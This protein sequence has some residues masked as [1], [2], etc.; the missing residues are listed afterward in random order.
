MMDIKNIFD[1]LNNITNTLDNVNIKIDNMVFRIE[2]LENLIKDKS[3]LNISDKKVINKT[4][5]L[6][7]LEHGF[8]LEKRFI[9]K[10]LEKNSIIGDVELFKE[11]YLRDDVN[12]PFNRKTKN[13]SYYNN[14]WIENNNNYIENTLIGNIIN[15][16]IEC[17]RME[18]DEFLNS[19][20]KTNLNYIIKLQ[21]NKQ[22]QKILIKSIFD[23]I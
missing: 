14:E 7:L 1:K 22:Y 15:T 6:C 5:N 20:Y 11:Y 3:I 2:N 23:L 21:T 18:T 13:I 12:I 9:Q 8:N 16:Y 17:M 4:I 19:N 10:C